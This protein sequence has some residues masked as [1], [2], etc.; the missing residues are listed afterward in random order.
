MNAR[1]GGGAVATTSALER[2]GIDRSETFHFVLDTNVFLDI[3]SV[4]DIAPLLNE[5]GAPLDIARGVY[6]VRRAA[7]GILLAA[8][9]DERGFQTLQL[10][11]ESFDKLTGF[12]PPERASIDAVAGFPQVF[13]HFV[14]D[15]VVPR[16]R[17]RTSPLEEAA[18]GRQCDEL[19]RDLAR[20]LGVPLITNESWSPEGV[21]EGDKRKLRSKAREAGVRV[22]TTE[23]ALDDLGIDR[24]ALAARFMERLREGA[25]RFL[26]DRSKEKR[27]SLEWRRVLDSLEALYRDLLQAYPGSH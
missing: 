27:D 10:R 12:A 5:S 19:L 17:A 25:E 18:E 8:T 4:H 16:W 26:A 22:F 21:R 7:A 2:L 3:A 1:A 9:F 13:G 15:Y 6:R 23:E 14:M 20:E 24:R 11:G